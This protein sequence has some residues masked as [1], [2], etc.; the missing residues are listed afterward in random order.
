[1]AVALLGFYFVCVCVSGYVQEE[2]ECCLFACKHHI[3][4]YNDNRKLMTSVF[5]CMCS[6]GGKGGFSVNCYL[7]W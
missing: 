2:K 5:V 1:M 6:V 3:P 4:W 7:K